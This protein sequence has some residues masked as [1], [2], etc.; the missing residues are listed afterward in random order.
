MTIPRLQKVLGK[1]R[2]SEYKQGLEP[3]FQRFTFNIFQFDLELRALLIKAVSVIEL[4]LQN[5]IRIVSKQ[6]KFD[7]FGHARRIL[8]ELGA[9]KQFL[10]ANRFGC[11]NGKEFRAALRVLND[12]R[13]RAAHHERIWNCKLDFCLPNS[14]KSASI[15]AGYFAVRDFSIG[16]ALFAAEH[17][18]SQFPEFINLAEEIDNLLSELPVEKK[19]VMNCMGFEVP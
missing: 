3:E 10:I 8:Q 17:L 9:S 15:E 14:L 18:L 13:N 4:A 7:S 16:G 5:Q 19:Y 1:P 2:Y 12:A 6:T 11:T